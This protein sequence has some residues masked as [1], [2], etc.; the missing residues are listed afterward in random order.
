MDEYH[1]LGEVGILGPDERT[2]LLDGEI[3]EMSPIGPRHAH[4]LDRF[5]RFLIEGIGR[6]A[7][8]RVQ[9]PSVLDER[10]EPQ[11]DVVVA[12]ER[13]GGYYDAHPE[14]RDIHLLVEVADSTLFFDRNRKLPRYASTGVREAWLV[15]L[16]VNR[17]EVYRDPGPDGYREMTTP[18]VLTPL[19]FPDVQIAVSDVLP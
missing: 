1:R 11:P 15:D 4:C 17:I 13:E 9:N 16:T 14:P 7:Y 19:D 5:T 18:D 3:I 2:E 10:S 6:R 12:R 8:V